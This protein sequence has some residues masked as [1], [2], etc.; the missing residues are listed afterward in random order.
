M[1]AMIHI[2]YSLPHLVNK[3]L[4]GTV[5]IVEPYQHPLGADKDQI[6]GRFSSFQLEECEGKIR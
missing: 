5:V 4:T 1:F 3:G 2:N 6:L